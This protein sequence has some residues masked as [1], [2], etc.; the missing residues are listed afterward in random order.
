MSD[1]ADA[2]LGEIAARQYGAVTRAQ[3]IGCHLSRGAI[4]HRISIGRLIPLFPGVF[5][6]GHRRR[7]RIAVA[8][9]AV[10]ACGAGAAL[11]H[12][13][14]AVLWGM[15]K[16][17]ELPVE[18]V[19]PNKRRTPAVRIH[20][21]TALAPRDIRTQLGI[22]TTSPA[23]T[24]LDIAPRLTDR[25]LA[26]AVND[27]RHNRYLTLDALADAL[28]RFRNHP[29]RRRLL[30]F[31][32]APTGPTRSELEDAFL[33]FTRRFDLPT[34]QM[35]VIVAGHL[36]DALFADEKLIVELDGF[37]FHRSRGS[38]ES[39]RERDADT[40]ASGHA[41]VRVTHG[42]LTNSAQ[43]EAARLQSILRER[44]PQSG[45]PPPRIEASSP[46]SGP[47]D[48]RS[49]TGGQT[50]TTVS[51]SGRSAGGTERPGRARA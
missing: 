30:P 46:S 13:S 28:D 38:F 17:W 21:S 10:L 18:V 49:I 5:A 50:E 45:M 3:L 33:D 1:A 37:E 26:R 51:N 7:E 24:L 23:R 20:V 44:R 2:A 22:R 40:L 48:R 32:E 25:A 14:A 11:S 16:R 31:L 47:N 4:A 6:V 12:S 43:R 41:T 8:S 35:N 9:A 36:V 39:D 19:V 29:G 15:R 27:A 34:P 42:R